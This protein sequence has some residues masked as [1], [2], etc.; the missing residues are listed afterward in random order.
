MNNDW[1]DINERLPDNDEFVLTARK[2]A[3]SIRINYYSSIL[4]QWMGEGFSDIT[5][6]RRLPPAPWE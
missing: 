6:W 2:G 3:K 5:H 4:N 1:I